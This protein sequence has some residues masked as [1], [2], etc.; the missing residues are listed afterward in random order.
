MELKTI[1]D[2][3]KELQISKQAVYKRVNSS[4]E[5]IEQLTSHTVKNGKR[6]YYTAQGQEI[7]KQ[8]FVVYL[9]QQQSTQ[10]AESELSENADNTINTLDKGQPEVNK[11]NQQSNGVKQSESTEVNQIIEA[12]TKQLEVKDK[13]IFD[14][15]NHVD[16]LTAAI[17]AEQE[18]AA[19]LTT[20]FTTALTQQQALHAGDIQR[21]LVEQCEPSESEPEI[22]PE[23]EQKKQSLFARL[24]KKRRGE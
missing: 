7:I 1:S 14:L 13:Q 4:P 5:I 20:A 19:Q 16:E 21:Q 11:S 8:L 9:R 23:P 3:A 17:K 24:F 15:Q 22:I 18:H 2:I 6:T 10:V 12:L